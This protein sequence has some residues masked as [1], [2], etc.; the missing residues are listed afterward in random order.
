MLL[1]ELFDTNLIK[2]AKKL[3]WDRTI[4]TDICQSTPWAL[5][6]PPNRG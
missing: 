3:I 6:E 1:P 5:S 4:E 2:D